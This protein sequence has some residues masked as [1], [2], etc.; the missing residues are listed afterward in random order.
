L[1]DGL[2]TAYALPPAVTIAV[3]LAL[4]AVVLSFAPA[5]RS[6]TSFVGMLGGLI[7]W[8]IA[9]L[10]MRL[11]PD[12]SIALQW[13]RWTPVA[14]YILFLFYFRFAREYTNT[15]DGNK[16]LIA[17]WVGLLVLIVAAPAG[18]L[19]EGLRIEDY[20]YAPVAGPLAVPAGA[21]GII[22][23]LAGAVTLRRRYRV[24]SSDEEKT[25][26]LYL[27]VAAILP[28]VG[29]LLDVGTNLPP[30]GIWTSLAFCVICSI[31]LLRYRLLDIPVFARRLLTY[32]VLGVLIAVPYVATL[33][34]LQRVLGARLD[35][36]WSFII[37][38]LLLALVLRP[39]YGAAQAVVDK[40]FYRDRYEALRALERFSREAQHSVD[41]QSLAIEVTTLVV[42]ALHAN[43]ACLFLPQPERGD[44]E[45]AHCAG[46]D[47]PSSRP[48]LSARGALA[49]WLAQHPGILAHRMLD[50]EPQLQSLS[51]RERSLLQSMGAS[52][53]I[54]VTSAGGQLAGLLALGEKASH[55]PYTGDDRRLLETLSN[56]LAVSLDNARLY[57]EAIRARRDLERWVDGME[58]SV[59]IV[60]P[61]HT[62]RF[63]NRSARE[64]LG[65]EAGMPCWS[66]LGNDRPCAV[67]SLIETFSG[68]TGS[69]RLSRHIR[70]RDYDVVAAPLLE[71][72][73]SVALITVLRDTTSRNR[74]EA[75]LR[76]S[77]AQLR[78]LASHQETVRE[79]ERRGIARE[80]HDELGQY[81]TALKMDIATLSRHAPSN[82]HEE[83]QEKLSGMKSVVEATILAVQ[84]MSSR[85]RPG[86]LDDL[87]LVPALEWLARDFQERS[88]LSCQLDVGEEFA[89]DE[90]YSTALFRICQESLTNVA[91][92]SHATRVSIQLRRDDASVVLTV[93]DNGRGIPKAQL[94][95]PHSFGVIGMRERARA[96]GGEAYFESAEGGGTIVRV[97]LPFPTE[98]PLKGAGQ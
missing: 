56:Q 24:S 73:G 71:P 1:T 60:A 27:I 70:E 96:L 68:G 92:H 72:D 66:S 84:R 62:I 50:I 53:I 58:D 23:L 82:A 14:L 38:V 78:D 33:F 37:T 17:G 34:V 5:S 46:M 80:L 25:R 10:G 20:G 49:R 61:D 16:V 52:I 28:L 48:V 67:C 6:R 89:F 79:E 65:V 31:A 94:D 8:G 15:H 64:D 22:L 9:V 51:Q 18:L 91:R 43:H 88:G 12:P 93:T 36:I 21:S 4:V 98:P 86:I 95:D 69:T 75:E 74:I 59:L 55:R 90:R 63:A 3:G 87:G 26:L 29:A 44:F 97:V 83:A 47:I 13:N 2:S 11:S 32:L 41:L 7:L 40:A 30:V 42:D 39:L 77:Q 45:L 54:P 35:P 85:L 76:S 57:S 81:L 19:M